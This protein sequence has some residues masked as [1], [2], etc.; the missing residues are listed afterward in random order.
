MLT[1]TTLLYFPVLAEQ[2]GNEKCGLV[3]HPGGYVLPGQWC[4][5]EGDGVTD[6]LWVVDGDGR[7]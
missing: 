4:G 7:F 5:G 1:L 6:S 3:D 2:L